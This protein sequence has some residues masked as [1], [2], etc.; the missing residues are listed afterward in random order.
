M[1]SLRRSLRRDP[2]ADRLT[3]L[4]AVGLAGGRLAIG[5]GIW[6]TPGPAL[7]GLGFDP[8]QAPVRALGRLAGT[9]DLATGALA[10]ATLGDAAAMRRVALAN[11]AID[12]GDALTFAIALVRRDGIDRAAVGGALSAATAAAAGAVLAAR[13]AP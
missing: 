7:R 8:G 4:L 12:A 10:I 5:T 9:R 1:P 11:A 6:L 13:L 3:R 2:A